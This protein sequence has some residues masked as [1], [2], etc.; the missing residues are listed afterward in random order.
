MY[1]SVD[2]LRGNNQKLTDT[3]ISD[4]DATTQINRADARLKI[5][6]SECVDFDA[7][8]A[9]IDT[10]GSTP[11]F[12]NLLS[13]YLATY[14]TL[15]YLYGGK[16]KVDEIDDVVFWRREYE[17]L[18]KKISEGEIN[19]GDFGTQESPSFIGNTPTFGLGTS[20]AYDDDKISEY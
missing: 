20:G 14:L 3:N 2:E 1:S 5:E 19:T 17:S 12:V 13:Q 18:K 8:D 16:R 4:A 15:S 11:A 6:L 9:Y 7:V 10:E